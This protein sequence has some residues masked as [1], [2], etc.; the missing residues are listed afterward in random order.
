M[1]PFVLPY[2]ALCWQNEYSHCGHC[3]PWRGINF[4]LNSWSETYRPALEGTTSA[5]AH[6]SSGKNYYYFFFYGTQKLLNIQKS[7]RPDNKLVEHPWKYLTNANWPS[8]FTTGNS[9]SSLLRKRGPSCLFINTSSSD[10][11]L[12]RFSAVGDSTGDALL[13]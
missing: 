6:Y 12:P 10:C 3:D 13:W 4:V 11:L 2:L 1:V 7:K 9:F 5:A 8:M